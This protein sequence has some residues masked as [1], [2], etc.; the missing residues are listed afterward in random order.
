[1]VEGKTLSVWYVSG[2]VEGFLRY[3]GGMQETEYGRRRGREGWEW[4]ATVL[5]S[6]V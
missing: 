2:P 4:T 3:N 1:L 6:K 5:T